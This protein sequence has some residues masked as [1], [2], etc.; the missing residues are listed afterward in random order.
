MMMEEVAG[1]VT[2]RLMKKGDLDQVLLI[3]QCSFPAPWATEAY[4][5]E[6]NNKFARYFVLLEQERVIGY[7]GMWLFAGE[8]HI[9]TIAVHPD[10]RS[11]GYGRML[12]ATLIEYSKEHHADTMILEV[13]VSNSSAIRLYSS[14]GFKRIGIRKNYYI[15]THEDA[16]VMLRHLKQGNDSGGRE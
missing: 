3:E 9:T 1:A 6:L 15:E 11:R 13:R 12:M 4:L 8:S 2:V 10:Y 7:A 14:M 16:I 5:S